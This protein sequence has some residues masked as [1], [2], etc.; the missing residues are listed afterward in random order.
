MSEYFDLFN[1]RYVKSVN[2]RNAHN[3]KKIGIFSL[4][5]EERSA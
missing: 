4:E 1:L 3:E 2:N 5:K